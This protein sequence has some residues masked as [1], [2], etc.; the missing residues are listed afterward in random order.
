MFSQVNCT[1]V[2]LLVS[3]Q[4][5]NDINAQLISRFVDVNFRKE[6]NGVQRRSDT[7]GV[8]MGLQSFY[9][10]QYTM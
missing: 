6:K 4:V 5:R 3:R 2:K 9:L 7:F 1:L 8:E 10:K